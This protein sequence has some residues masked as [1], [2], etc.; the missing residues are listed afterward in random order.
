MGIPNQLDPSGK[1]KK[2]RPSTS[3]NHPSIISRC[4]VS[5]T[6]TRQEDQGRLG[7]ELRQ[8][9]LT[10][11]TCVC[12][13]WA[14][15]DD[16]RWHYFCWSECGHHGVSCQLVE[17]SIWGIHLRKTKSL[18]TRWE[19]CGSWWI[20]FFSI[21]PAMQGTK[22][23]ASG[24]WQSTRNTSAR[25]R[26][27]GS[28]C[29]QWVYTGRWKHFDATEYLIWALPSEASCQMC[30]FS[31]KRDGHDWCCDY[32]LE[33]GANIKKWYAYWKP[34][35]NPCYGLPLQLLEFACTRPSRCEISTEFSSALLCKEQ[36]SVCAFENQAKRRKKT[37]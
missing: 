25:S 20:I 32:L 3:I 13:D 5:T 23:S 17:D 15:I 35:K 1:W 10:W 28:F 16:W 4:Q 12:F 6:S 36:V 31:R 37:L 2:M 27:L 14:A 21:E 26:S 8:I 18:G 24:T 22:Q 33:R 30:L 34:I 7:T 9:L 29:L 19:A 11:F